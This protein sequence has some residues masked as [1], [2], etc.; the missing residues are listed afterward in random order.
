MEC[1]RDITFVLKFVDIKL[2]KLLIITEEVPHLKIEIKRIEESDKSET[3]TKI[4]CDG[5]IR[6]PEEI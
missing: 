2:S 3:N 6:T 4:V 1:R 5:P